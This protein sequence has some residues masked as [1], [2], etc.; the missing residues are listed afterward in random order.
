MAT[1][2]SLSVQ[3]AKL[4]KQVYRTPKTLYWI[5]VYPGICYIHTKV[6]RM[7]NNNSGHRTGPVDNVALL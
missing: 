7:P 3:D 6:S 4:Q 5:G 2:I 1:S